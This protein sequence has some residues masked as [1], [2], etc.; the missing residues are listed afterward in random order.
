MKM[1]KMFAGLVALVAGMALSAG[2]AFATKG[3]VSGDPA[4]MKLVPYYETGDTKATIIGIQ[5]MSPQEQDTMD[6]NQDVAD[7][8]AYLGG[9]EPTAPMV[10][11][12]TPLLDPDPT[13]DTALDMTNLNAVAGVEAA[14]EKAM[15]A[16]YT[17]HL[18]IMVNVY[19]KM[20]MM[21]DD[22]SATLCLQEHE[23]GV[24]VLQGAMDEMMMDS[25][26]MK[27]L[28]V[29]D[30]EIPEYGYV[31]VMAESRKFTGC[32]ATAPNSLMNVDTRDTAGLASGDPVYTGADT[33]VST[34]AIIQDTGMGFFGTEV[35]TSTVEMSSSLGTDGAVGGG[36]DGDPELACYGG[37]G[38]VAATATVAANQTGDFR[39]SRCG[40][41]PERHTMGNLNVAT[42]TNNANAIARYDIGDESMVYLW[43]AKGMDTDDT[44]ASKRRM[45]DVVVKCEDGTVMMDSDLDGN[46]MPFKVAAPSML[47]MIDPSMGDL[48]MATDECA[49]D[50]GVLKITMPNGSHAG[51]AFTHITQMMGHYRMNFPGY[52]IASM[53]SCTIDSANKCQGMD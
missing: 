32:G 18:F 25:N 2:S 17:E 28:S 44:M 6:K 8:T 45:L 46:M 10:T 51:M 21:M 30:E 12:L 27:V 11:N 31:K 1:N 36:D 22:A 4:M 13:A 50:R 20:G 42:T 14:L 49:G 34:W 29:M 48:G 47:T 38:G 53:D 3:Y 23:F 7:L 19:D 52:S 15:M 33:M 9:A 5:N 37:T 35:P 16:Q 41:I 40:L 24:V 26:K 43:L 39:M